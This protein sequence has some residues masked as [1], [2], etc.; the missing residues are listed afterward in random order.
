MK[1][2][3]IS[4]EKDACGYV[5]FCKPGGTV[6]HPPI[7]E[8]RPL[9]DKAS[10]PAGFYSDQ[11]CKRTEPKSATN[12]VLQTKTALY[13]SSSMFRHLDTDKLSSKGMIAQKLFYPGANADIMLSNLK[14]DITK[15]VEV[16]DVIF[17]M[18]G[19]NNIDSI[20]YGSK[21]LK[22][23]KDGIGNLIR[24]VEGKFPSSKINVINILPRTTAGKN[25]VVNELN[26]LIENMCQSS[27]IN[28]MTTKH[29]FNFRDGK[30]IDSYFLPP[31]SWIR[32]NC[33]LNRD[34]IT[35]LG[36]YLKYWTYRLLRE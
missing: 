34:G 14:A 36:K 2:G 32:D 19:T 1:C 23:A 21:E 27:G 29:L 15:I 13:I 8:S 26:F 10:L 7:E 16:P 5:D 25:D 6:P 24:Y 31:N 20:Y 28:F 33:H 30:R 4:H 9:P 12:E 17:I 11:P 35:R 18:C 22:W 3:A